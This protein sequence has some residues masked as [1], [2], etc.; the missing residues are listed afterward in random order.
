MKLP[1]KIVFINIVSAIAVTLLIAMMIKNS[2]TEIFALVSA[3][4]GFIF[5][6][7]GLV[8]LRKNHKEYAQG[9]LLSG[10]ILMLMGFLIC[11]TAF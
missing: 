8:L 9:F 7:T 6:V 11:S 10:G 5:T 2:F 3:C 1:L 4:G